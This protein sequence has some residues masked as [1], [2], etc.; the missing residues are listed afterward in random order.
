MTVQDLNRTSRSLSI[1]TAT[2]TSYG[3]LWIIQVAKW[4][5]NPPTCCRYLSQLMNSRSWGSW[6][7]WVLTYCHRAWMITGLVWVWMPSI[8]ASR[9]SS[10]N[11]GGCWNT[12][13]WI[14]VRWVFWPHHP[15]CQTLGSNLS[16]CLKLSPEGTRTEK[17]H[18]E[19]YQHL[20][21]NQASAGQCSEHPHHLVSSLG[22]HQSP[23]WWR[24]CATKIT[25]IQFS[26]TYFHS[27]NRL[28]SFVRLRLQCQQSCTHPGKRTSGDTVG[29]A[30]R[31]TN[32]K[33]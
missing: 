7:L 23:G 26:K 2:C 8:R 9:G 32:N 27:E 31:L 18:Q 4:K 20:P 33:T 19:N 12:E 6:S 10:L 13:V 17:A 25:E 21:G 30:I 3:S 1:I 14:K 16:Q 22:N 15:H 29:R 28:C 11:W 5:F 24:S